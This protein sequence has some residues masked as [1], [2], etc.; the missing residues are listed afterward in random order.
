MGAAMKVIVEITRE[1]EGHEQRILA[2]TLFDPPPV[3]ADPEDKLEWLRESFYELLMDF[4]SSD[5]DHVDGKYVQ[6]VDEDSYTD[7]RWPK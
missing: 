3:D 1:Y 6:L 5:R 7:F 2:V 4:R